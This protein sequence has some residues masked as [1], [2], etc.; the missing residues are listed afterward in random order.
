[1][2]TP[3]EL[4]FPKDLPDDLK[5][6]LSEHHVQ[7]D[8]PLVALLAWHWLRIN[9]NRDILRESM[10]QFTAALDERKTE[11]QDKAYK[12]EALLEVRL[13]QLNGW[14]KTL[15]ELTGHLEDLSKVLSEKPLAISE[16]ITKELA[17]PIGQSVTVVKQ[18]SIDAKSLLTDVEVSRKRLVWS[19]FV[20]TYL[21]G[22]TTGALII[23]WIY[24][25]IFLH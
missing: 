23:S 25:H 5:L 10:A 20:T 8:D 18:L 9:Q 2:T 15:Q 19:H 21:V 22:F 4:V 6:I 7:K 17:H 16:Q 12:I 1:M 13:T 3:A 11:I 14:T 24:S